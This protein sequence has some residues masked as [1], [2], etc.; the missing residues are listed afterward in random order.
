MK[1]ASNI[2]GALI[3]SRREAVAALAHASDNSTRPHCYCV[4]FDHD[5]ASYSATD[6]HRLAIGFAEFAAG[7]PRERIPRAHPAPGVGLVSR[8]TLAA[9]IKACD[10]KGWIVAMPDAARGTSIDV[11]GPHNR[12]IAFD[13]TI[14]GPPIARFPGSTHEGVQG[15]P[16]AQLVPPHAWE[17]VP[18]RDPDA[19]RNARDPID[20]P[21]RESARRVCVDPDYLA[22]AAEFVRAAHPD[23]GPRKGKRETGI[24]FHAPPS[25]FDPILVRA[26][27]VAAFVVVMPRRG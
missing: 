26:P 10:P 12:G 13:G 8:D 14:D 4:S 25:P 27:G 15:P 22:D 6:G 2:A 23:A 18:D 21:E 3:L 17:R 16:I 24:A 11:Y 20:V 7:E 1:T 5:R 9:A 19:D